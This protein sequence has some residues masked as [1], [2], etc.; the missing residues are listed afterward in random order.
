MLVAA[1][2]V[3][4]WS[5]FLFGARVITISLLCAAASAAADTAAAFLL[6]RRLRADPYA[7]VFGLLADFVSIHL[8]P[9]FLLVLMVLMVWMAEQMNR[10][11]AGAA[12]PAE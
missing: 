7:A 4:V 2:P 6:R 5:V 10:R 8:L 11:V 3:L 1:L 9:V 12:A